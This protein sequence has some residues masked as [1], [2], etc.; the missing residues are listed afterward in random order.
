VDY[1]N[2]FQERPRGPSLFK[3]FVVALLGAVLGGLI[4]FYGLQYHLESL[5]TPDNSGFSGLDV[6]ESRP[7]NT[8]EEDNEELYQSHQQ[9]PVVRAAREVMPSVVGVSN[10][11]YTFDLRGGRR[12][13]RAGT[14]SGFVITSDGYILTNN[15]VIENAAEVVVTFGSGEE[16]EAQIVGA[17]PPTDLAVL[18]V[19]KTDLPAVR[20]ADSDKLQVG[21]QVIAIGNPLGLEFQQSVTVGYISA[22]ER[23]LTI[24][25]FTYK[26]IQTDAAINSGNSGGPLVNIQGKVVGI[27]T[28]KVQ[29]SGVEGM[30]FAIPSNIARTIAEDLI[31]YQ[32]VCRP[33]IGV[34]AANVNAWAFREYGLSIN[35]G[36]VI[37]RVIPG[38]PAEKVGLQRG[39]VIVA[40]DDE[41]TRNLAQLQ[42]ALSRRKIGDKVT[43]TIVRGTEELQVEL[44]LG[45]MPIN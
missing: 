4:V 41:A 22:T 11:A 12:L 37:D 16:V 2:D 3:Y 27:N 34:D 10:F 13:V 7:G 35:Y 39:D 42:S 36:V 33:T 1:F 9:T 23:L 40:I 15:H 31:R 20:F 45:E 5:P 6:E 43:L 17:D 30:G 29:L 21:E 24:G 14:G 18:K 25:D 32:R 19:N 44:T 8:E 28:A 38:T 26:V